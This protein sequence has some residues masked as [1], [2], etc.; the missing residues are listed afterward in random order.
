M[1][2]FV[3]VEML[4]KTDLNAWERRDNSHFEYVVQADDETLEDA[5]N[6]AVAASL[7]RHGHYVD[8]K[9]IGYQLSPNQCGSPVAPPPSSDDLRELFIMIDDVNTRRASKDLSQ[10]EYAAL[11]SLLD[12]L[13]QRVSQFAAA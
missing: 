4:R 8:A 7:S 5:I 9:V 6:R 12:N 2:N 11:R 10:D 13:N 3:L 1:S